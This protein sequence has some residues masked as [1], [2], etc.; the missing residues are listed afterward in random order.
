AHLGR[1]LPLDET[2]ATHLYRIAQEALTNAMRHSLATAVV[3]RLSASAGEVQLEICDDGCGIPAAALVESDGLGLKIM[4]Y[5]AQMLGGRLA[6]ASEP[7]RGATVRCSC[8][9]VPPTENP[10]P[11]P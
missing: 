6:F 10:V 5:R 2:A 1:N 7:D 11:P 4:R 9:L 8:P 3:I